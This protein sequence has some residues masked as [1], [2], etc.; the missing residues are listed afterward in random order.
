MLPRLP[1]NTQYHIS[2]II[3]SQGRGRVLRKPRLV[4]IFWPVL[5]SRKR[6]QSERRWLEYWRG[7]GEFLK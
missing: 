2:R 7:T 1:E 6:A 3:P 4:A 5:A